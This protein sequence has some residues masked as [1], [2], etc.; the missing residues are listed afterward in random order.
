MEGERRTERGHCG[1]SKEWMMEDMSSS[2]ICPARTDRVS[3]GQRHIRLFLCLCQ[4][5]RRTP[6]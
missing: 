4:H 6:L 3:T 5:R 1:T 2:V